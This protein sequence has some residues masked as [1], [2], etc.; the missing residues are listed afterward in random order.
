MAD[1]LS[2]IP[3]I[4]EQ[5]LTNQSI[6]SAPLTPFKRTSALGSF[7]KNHR[8][9][10]GIF[11]LL[12]SLLVG[13]G[14]FT[15]IQLSQDDR[16]KAATGVV[17]FAF[18][19]TSLSLA[20]GAERT[21]QLTVDTGGQQ[22]SG[23]VIPLQFNPQFL[24]I[25]SLTT[26]AALPVVLEQPAI[27]PAG[28][29]QIIIGANPGAPMTA[30]GV[31]AQ[32][33][34]KAGST[35]TTETT[36]NYDASRLQASAIGVDSNVAQ[37]GAPIQVSI[38]APVS[39]S[40]SRCLAEGS[41][42]ACPNIQCDDT[43]N[44]TTLEPF[45]S[46]TVDNA[47]NGGGVT[48]NYCGEP[49]TPQTVPGAPT[50]GTATAGNGY[51][52]IAFSAPASDGGSGIANYT[53]TANPGGATATGTTSAITI[54]GL[55]NGTAYTFTVT[56]TNGVGT[57]P[58]SAASNSVTPTAPTPQA[59][60]PGAPINVSATAGNT[61]AIVSFSAPADT[62]GA[63]ITSYTVTSNPEGKTATGAGS[64]LTVTGLTNGTAYTFTVTATNSVGTSP[65]S[66]ASGA[67]T[68]IADVTPP[69]GTPALNLQ[70]KLQG[71]N[72]AGITIP[73]EVTLKY[74][75][76][77]GTPV[78]KV[79]NKSY[80]SGENGVLAENSPI[81]IVGFELGSTRGIAE[82]VEVFVKTPTSLQKKLGVVTL[83]PNEVAN[84][85]T[86]TLLPVG[87]FKRGAGEVNLI[88]LNDIALALTQYNELE[89]PITD[90]N[91]EY[92][93]NFDNIYTLQ[94]IAIVLTNLEQLE[95]PGDTP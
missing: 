39:A 77:G 87:D 78:I 80:Y 52:T 68:P 49:A 54:S 14:L 89:N 63:A 45:C 42:Y 8:T 61:A 51:A 48:C 74:T 85:Q 10:L 72:K 81:N 90:S 83:K 17:T 82:N 28:R 46:K 29:A 22:I 25:T 21:I 35:P 24:T 20:P 86:T 60:A 3:A 15:A 70:F 12:S 6:S 4:P 31:I 84:L 64:P 38:A 7:F 1:L 73:A 71:L 62:G 66:A 88:K 55:T 16:S 58:A 91:R 32:I 56:A 9:F 59:T 92:D 13:A 65:A 67:V 43:G 2:P 36:I 19:Q 50:I 5:P 53:V 11:V 93:V 23:A 40:C 37:L 79:F 34:V 18:D 76:A 47:E 26:R 44:C 69:V 94:D 33:T 27:D 57:S 95:Y 30:N 75:P 41:R